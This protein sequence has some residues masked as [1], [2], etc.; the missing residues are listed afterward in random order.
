ML[1]YSTVLQVSVVDMLHYSTVLQVS[2]VDML[3][4]STVLQ[5]SVVD[6]L[7]YSTVLQVS[8]LDM[9]HYSSPTGEMVEGMWALSFRRLKIIIELG[10]HWHMLC[11]AVYSECV[12]Y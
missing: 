6:M 10:K 2:V 9:L 3:H 4:Y 7:H 5:V 12:M 8:V 1:H 11:G